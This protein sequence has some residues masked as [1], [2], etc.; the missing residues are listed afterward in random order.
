[1]YGAMIDSTCLVQQTSCARKG[2]C[3]LYDQDLFR[4]RFHSLP[5]IAKIGAL[6]M[7]ALAMYMSVRR[8]RREDR[9][10]TE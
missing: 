9:I 5:V 3:L 2:A 4:L 1:M 8:D 7:Y 6:I 10:N